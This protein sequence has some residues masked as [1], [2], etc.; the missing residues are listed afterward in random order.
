MLMKG[1][2]GV[3]LGVANQRSIAWGITQ[4]LLKQGADVAVTCLNDKNR[5]TLKKLLVDNPEVPI[6]EC[7]VTKPETI[8][9][10]FASLQEKYG[11]IDFVVHCLAF[12]DKADLDGGFINTSLEGFNLANDISAYSLVALAKAAKPLM[13][14]GG[15]IVALTYLGAERIVTNYNVMGVAKAALECS[16]RYLAND[17]GPDGIRVNAISAG[18]IKTLAARGIS[19]FSRMLKVQE[20]I[21]PL[22]KAN[23]IDEVGDVAMF[24]CSDLSRGITAEI[25]YVDAG[26]NSVG[27]GP[28]DAYNLD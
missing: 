20:K 11:Q 25:M 6:F 3:V 12:A 10:T 24:L 21:S 17:M 27:L 23:T 16:V 28:M 22:R 1:K 26:F 8:E 19:N 7:D 5:Q 15:S 13:T 4:S 2:R 9:S 14:E 18:P